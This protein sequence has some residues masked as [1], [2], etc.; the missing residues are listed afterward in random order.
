M[1][2]RSAFI[3]C[4]SKTIRGLKKKQVLK[5]KVLKRLFSRIAPPVLYLPVVFYNQ[6][7]HLTI[8]LPWPGE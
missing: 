3:L 2:N 6:N 1:L 5:A 7:K 8:G 4:F